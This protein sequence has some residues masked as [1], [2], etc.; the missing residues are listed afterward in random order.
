[1]SRLDRLNLGQRIIIVIAL[2]GVI[3]LIGDW[4]TGAGTVYGWV[5]YAP[6]SRAA[7][8]SWFASHWRDLYWILMV[9]VW[10]GA[11]LLVMRS[12]RSE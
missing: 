7:G 6:L 2:A 5:A 1:V 11:S 3:T 12:P 8:P 10:A 9:L 4:A